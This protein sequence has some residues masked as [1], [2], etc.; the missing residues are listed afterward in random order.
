[1]LLEGIV[2]GLRSSDLVLYPS[3]VGSPDAT[4]SDLFLAYCQCLFHVDASSLVLVV[5]LTHVL[6]GG[7][8][9]KEQIVLWGPESVG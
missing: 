1:M 5:R 7:R 3:A 4:E 8:G 2:D 9:R 6:G